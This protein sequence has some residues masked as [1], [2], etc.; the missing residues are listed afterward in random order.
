MAQVTRVNHGVAKGGKPRAQLGDPERRGAHV[1]AA[2]P[3]TEV[4]R[5][6][7][8]LQRPSA[9]HLGMES[10]ASV[11]RGGSLRRLDDA[12]N[13][14]ILFDFRLLECLPRAAPAG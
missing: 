9:W 1:N 5:H 8:Q 6:A 14:L 13:I 2:S 4:E 10:A 11:R 7:D 12:H 3:G